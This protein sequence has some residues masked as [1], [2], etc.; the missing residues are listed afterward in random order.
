MRQSDQ[1]D[2]LGG[3]KVKGKPAQM[4]L[5]ETHR[6]TV[7]PPSHDT[8]VRSWT[9]AASYAYYMQSLARLSGTIARFCHDWRWRPPK[10][11]MMSLYRAMFT[12]CKAEVATAYCV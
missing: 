6:E 2:A 4:A 1:S 11:C 12:T 3:D 7:T 10:C 8:C 5:N 9:L